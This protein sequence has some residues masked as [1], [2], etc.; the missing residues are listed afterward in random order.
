M[1]QF[2][3]DLYLRSPPN[4]S[5][6]AATL[7]S[8]LWGLGYPI[9]GLAKACRYFALLL[10]ETGAYV[11]R[12]VALLCSLDGAGD[13]EDWED[14]EGGGEQTLLEYLS[15]CWPLCFGGTVEHDDIAPVD[16]IVCLD[17]CF[18]QKRRTPARGSGC[19]AP[20]RHPRSVFL[21]EGEL[22][23]AKH[24]VE[25]ARPPR[26]PA[27]AMNAADSV[28][29]GMK[30]SQSVP[31]TCSESFKAADENRLK[32]SPTFFSD[33]G[34]MALLCHHD[35]VL[36]LA[37]VTTP[38]EQQFYVIALILK[39]FKAIPHHMTVGILYDIGCQL[40]RSCVK[41]DFIPDFIDRIVWGISVFHTYGHQWPCQ[42]IYHLRKCVRFG[43]SDG[44]GCERFWSSIQGLIPSLH[45]SGYHQRIFSLDL[46]IDFLRDNGLNDLATWLVR[47][48]MACQGKKLGAEGVLAKSDLSIRELEVLWADQVEVQTRSLVAETAGLAKAAIKK[49]ITK[50]I[51]S[52]DRMV[53]AGSADVGDLEDVM[54]QIRRKRGELGVSDRANLKQMESSQYL[55]L[56]IQAK[57]Q[58][59]KF[60]LERFNRV[61]LHTTASERR[62]TDHI[63]SQVSRHEPTIV[64]VAQC[65][66]M[67]VDELESLV[68]KRQAPRHAVAPKHLNR[69][70]LFPLGVDD[71]IWN[72]HGLDETDTDAPRWLGD[73]EVQGCITAMLTVDHCEE[74]ECHLI[75]EAVL[76][77]SWY[78]SKWECLDHAIHRSQDGFRHY[79]ER[80]HEHLVYLGASWCELLD[81]TEM[82][83]ELGTWGPSAQDF[84]SAL[85][86]FSGHQDATGSTGD[87]SEASNTL[88]DEDDFT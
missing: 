11:R 23:D 45:V 14:D 41:W 18:T 52:L 51:D 50:E 61:Y 72:D 55:K 86:T 49:S 35:R 1:L 15:S 80:K 64:K 20:V 53:K 9:P 66:N 12:R 75:R 28:K 76:L 85:A 44:E 74:E 83:D 48:W 59:H 81:G 2:A 27:T 60:E 54:V 34:L 56:R 29:E 77:Q 31:D 73:D 69:D 30:L 71:P 63:K 21:T 7:E 6:F 36:W 26:A 79:L 32:A 37:N 16:V 10:V 84:G 68:H 67:L 22:R 3:R 38:G 88:E 4:R 8:Y 5:A 58:N 40:H 13:G 39:L 62:L 19:D 57:L 42:L 17:T 24:L 43:L 47:K 33:T 46:Q 65:F 25:L 78:T 82:G 70:S 87:S